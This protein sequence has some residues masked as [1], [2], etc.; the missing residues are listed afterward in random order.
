MKRFI[1]IVSTIVILAAC[2]TLPNPSDD[3]TALVI[4]EIRLINK[5]KEFPFLQE[6]TLDMIK[7]IIQSVDTGNKFELLSTDNGLF[8]TTK[9]KSGIYEIVEFGIVRQY[10]NENNRLV[11]YQ[12]WQYFTVVNG[13]INNLGLIIWTIPEYGNW[14]IN[15][16]RDYESLKVKFFE[17]YTKNR[18]NE[19]EWINRGFPIYRGNQNNKSIQKY[20]VRG[21]DETRY[22]ELWIFWHL[23]ADKQVGKY[24]LPALNEKVQDWIDRN[25]YLVPETNLNAVNISSAIGKK[26]ESDF[27]TLA[28][29]NAQNKAKTQKLIIFSYKDIDE[30]DFCEIH[31]LY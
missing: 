28:L 4:G 24:P 31:V 29:Y 3:G 1:I 12:N 21:D 5:N 10:N 18:W 19:T 6:T 16:T 13:K 23:I 2:S 14:K 25:L 9:L 22:Q 15:Y 20:V 17:K 30:N 11:A 8:F 7:I 26:E 27:T